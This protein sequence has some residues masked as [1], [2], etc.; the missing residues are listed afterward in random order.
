MSSTIFIAVT[1]IG[2]LIM[3][4]LS[5]MIKPVRGLFK[6]ILHTALGWGMLLLWNLL[7]PGFS[8]GINPAS[9]TISGILGIPGLL[10]MVLVKQLFQL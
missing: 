4:M 6:L 8:I 3:L 1:V 10:L 5:L 7:L 9:A 2:I